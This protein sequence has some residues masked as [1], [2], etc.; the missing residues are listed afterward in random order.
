MIT[1]NKINF[2]ILF[3]A[4]ILAYYLTIRVDAPNYELKL[5]RHT[6]IINNTIE[7]PYK[8]RLLNPYITEVWRTI[9]NTALPEKPSFVF[10][11][12]FQSF[13]V[14]AFML[15]VLFRFFSHWFDEIGAI[16]SLL[17]F[18]LLVPLSL[19]GYDVLGDMTT[20]GIMALGFL[21]ILNDK[22]KFLFPLVFIAAFNELQAIILVAFYF[23]GRTGNFKDKR[24]WLNSILL[25][26]IFLAAYAFIY[27]L[28]GGSAGSSEVEWYFTKDAAF[29]LAHKDWIPLW[30][31]M[32]APLLVFVF[33]RFSS[34]P[35]FL[36]TS[37]LIVLPLFYFGAFFFIA[38]L[39]EIDKALTIFTILIP[40]ALFSIIPKHVKGGTD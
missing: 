20:A 24:I 34:K 13:L 37:A 35:E 31:I 39:R 22:I 23:L 29:N 26:L 32:I 21:F 2:I 15:F 33:K 7:Y 38:R 17:L 9:L 30:I 11:Y 40:L 25:V 8:Y 19:T 3:G 12:F 4:L 1:K 6:T 5:V 27:L 36:K 18:A 14:F 10:A 28:R 16:I